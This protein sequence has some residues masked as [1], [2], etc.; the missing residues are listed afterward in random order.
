MARPPGAQEVPFPLLSKVLPDLLC[1]WVGTES[2]QCPG[3]SEA[4]QRPALLLLKP[5]QDY[6]H[7]NFPN[8]QGTKI[9]HTMQ[10]S[11]KK[12]EISLCLSHLSNLVTFSSFFPNFREASFISSSLQSQSCHLAMSVTH[13]ETEWL[14]CI[15]P[16]NIHSTGG[17]RAGPNL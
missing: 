15:F 16:C 17:K 8:S 12:K 1:L 6:L 10:H 5:E 14:T 3:R 11:R 4:G 2:E 7:F 13:H 9:P